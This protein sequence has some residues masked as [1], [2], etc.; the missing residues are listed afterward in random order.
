MTQL[1]NSSNPSGPAASVSKTSRVSS[2]SALRVF[3]LSSSI[4]SNAS[5]AVRLLPSRNSVSSFVRFPISA[6]SDVS[7]LPSRN[8]V[9]SSVRFPIS[10]GSSRMPFSLK[11]SYRWRS[12]AASLISFSHLRFLIMHPGVASATNARNPHAARTVP[13]NVRSYCNGGL[14]G[15]VS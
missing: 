4:S 3:P 12:A 5:S 10:A 7:S 15:T 2:F 11:R 14:M 13:P 8:S 6:G 1:Q 9:S